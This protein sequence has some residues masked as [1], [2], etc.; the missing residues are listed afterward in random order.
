MPEDT[1][2]PQPFVYRTIDEAIQAFEALV[3]AYHSEDIVRTFTVQ[4]GGYAG[5]VITFRYNGT[6]GSALVKD[7]I[8]GNSSHDTNLV[9]SLDFS[10]S[11]WEYEK[12]EGSIG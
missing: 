10:L 3:P 8:E 1:K 4:E 2:T 6:F 9:D 11:D 5:Y 12:S 7:S